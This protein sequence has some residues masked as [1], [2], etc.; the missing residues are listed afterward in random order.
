[1]I[2]AAKR[3]RPIEPP[4]KESRGL[5]MSDEEAA[6]QGCFAIIRPGKRRA[7]RILERILFPIVRMS[8]RMRPRPS[9]TS[10]VVQKILVVEY[11]LLGDAIL[12]LPFLHSLRA[13]Y[14]SSHITLLVNPSVLGLLKY[15][16]LADEMVSVR[17]PWVEHFS[18]LGQWN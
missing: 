18:R 5:A 2:N 15:Q 8:E 17:L 11:S 4:R 1:M 3:E 13:H 10:D 7:I 16:D 6:A 12:L 14:P 9:M